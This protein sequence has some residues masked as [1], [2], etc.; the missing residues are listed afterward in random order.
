MSH[1]TRTPR[2]ITPAILTLARGLVQQPQLRF[3]R[4]SAVPGAALN[5]CFEAVE[6]QVLECGGE[7]VYG[8]Q[9]WEWPLVMVEAEFHAVWCSPEGELIDITP[10]GNSAIEILFLVDPERTY[11][12]RQVSNVRHPLSADRRVIELIKVC[13]AEYEFMNRGS[14][15]EQHGEIAIE[16]DEAREFLAIQEH[17]RVLVAELAGRRLGRNEPCPCGSG[18]KY[19]KCCG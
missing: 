7:V 4:V 11:E 3:L 1:V 19:K 10:K 8:W 15:S 14:R 18:S 17:R 2:A 5:E 13:E 16:G 9:V 6:K 12:G